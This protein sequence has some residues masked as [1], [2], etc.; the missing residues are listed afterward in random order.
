MLVPV[1]RLSVSKRYKLAILHLIHSIV[2]ERGLT[3]DVLWAYLGEVHI[4]LLLIGSDCVH[5]I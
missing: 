3:R 4:L 5:H 1:E 2:A